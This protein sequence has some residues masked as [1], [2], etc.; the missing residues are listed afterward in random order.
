MKHTFFPNILRTMFTAKRDRV[1]VITFAFLSDLE[2]RI[3]IKTSLLT[4]L[5]TPITITYY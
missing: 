1:K 2:L 3:Y 5:K 4:D